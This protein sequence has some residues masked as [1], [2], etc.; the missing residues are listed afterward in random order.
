MKK[1]RLHHVVESESNIT[2]EV[3]YSFLENEDGTLWVGTGT[4]LFM[5]DPVT[6]TTWPVYQKELGDKLCSSLY[7][8]SRGRIWVSTFFDGFYCIDRGSVRSYKDHS[9]ML[10]SFPNPN[11]AQTVFEDKNG[12]FWVSVM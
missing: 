2:N 6:G 4:G 9:L 10:N 5:Y 11:N 7:R 3:I 8:D 1:F 12:N